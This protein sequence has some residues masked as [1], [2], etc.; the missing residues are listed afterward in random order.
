MTGLEIENQKAKALLLYKKFYRFF[1]QDFK[2]TFL[3]D[4]I[5]V[6]NKEFSNEIDLTHGNALQEFEGLLITQQ[7][8]FNEIL[9][10]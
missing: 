2:V 7:Q 5:H 1:T 10:I 6:K 9:K 3:S 8:V 4:S